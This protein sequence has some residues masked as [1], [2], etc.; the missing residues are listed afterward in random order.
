MIERILIAGTGGQGVVTLGKLLAHAAMEAYPFV[1]FF[2]SYSAEVRGGASNC[3]VIISTTEIFS[4][5]A[6]RFDTVLAMNQTAAEKFISFVEQKG[7]AL[8]NSTLCRVNQLDWHY[9]KIQA[10]KIADQ[11]G[12]VRAANLVMLGA[13]LARKS[14]VSLSKM[15]KTIRTSFSGLPKT[16]VKTNLRAF[17][18]GLSI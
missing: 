7:L 17:Y 3:Q 14:V 1:T 5:L 11:L 2:P 13:M 8:A 9:I 12:N 6:E 4:P 10:T 15:E 16:I 18:W